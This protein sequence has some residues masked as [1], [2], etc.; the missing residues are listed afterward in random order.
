MKKKIYDKLINFLQ[1]SIDAINLDMTVSLATLSGITQSTV[2]NIMSGKTKNSKPK[3]L[4]KLAIGLGMT[5]SGLFFI[6]TRHLNTTDFSSLSKYNCISFFPHIHYTILSKLHY[7]GIPTENTMTRT[8][9]YD[10]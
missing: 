6:S 9:L 4:H 3:T 8:K 5:V 10:F 2:E 7:M 1:K